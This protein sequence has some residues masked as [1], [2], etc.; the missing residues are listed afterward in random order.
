MGGSFF[1]GIRK[2]T[3]LDKKSFRVLTSLVCNNDAE[4]KGTLPIGKVYYFKASNQKYYKTRA[5]RYFNLIKGHIFT[6]DKACKKNVLWCFFPMYHTEHDHLI[7]D[8]L[9]AFVL[10]FELPAKLYDVKQHQ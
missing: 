8:E 4:I 2:E 1:G 10:W 3:K 6:M 7:I 5:A 9:N